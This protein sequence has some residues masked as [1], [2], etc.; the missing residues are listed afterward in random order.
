VAGWIKMPLGREVGLGPIHIVLD[1]DPPPLPKKGAQ[2]PFFGPFLLWPT[3]W[4][5]QDAT[6]YGSRPQLRQ[7]CVRWD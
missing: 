4:M 2:P 6:W 1:G 5:H 7:H 3:S